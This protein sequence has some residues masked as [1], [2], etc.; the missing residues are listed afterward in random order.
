MPESHKS[1]DKYLIWIEEMQTQPHLE[2]ELID[3]YVDLEAKSLPKIKSFADRWINVNSAGKYTHL[4]YFYLYPKIWT[5]FKLDLVPKKKKILFSRIDYT[6]A[7]LFQNK[8]Y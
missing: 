3:M 8:T 5:W 4:S 7:R 1:V 2:D 6:W